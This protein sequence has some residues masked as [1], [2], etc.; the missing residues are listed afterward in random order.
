MRRSAPFL[1]ALGLIVAAA[2]ACAA[3]FVERPPRS[4]PAVVI[5]RPAPGEVVLEG[6]EVL[7]ESTSVDAAGVTEVE[8]Y[9]DGQLL[10]IDVS[11]E[12]GGQSP[13]T[14]AQPWVARGV[15]QHTV[16]VK[17]ANI[18]GGQAESAPL[19]LEVAVAAA[20][21]GGGAA[22]P[23][24][25][26]VPA[27][28]PTAVVVMITPSPTSSPTPRPTAT[29]APAAP[30]ATP[31]PAVT[32]ADFDDTGLRPE[33]RFLE[34]WTEL[35][36]GRGGLGYPLAA[37]TPD[38][39][40]ARQYF[41]GGFMYWWDSP[42]DPNPI[43]VFSVPD[44]TLASGASWTR[45]DDRWDGRDRYSC[46]AARE[47]PYGPVAGFG[48]VWCD[49]ARVRNALGSPL[50]PEAGSAGNAPFGQVQFFQGGAMLY[51]PLNGEVWVLFA[52]DG[53][54]RFPY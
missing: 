48:K 7:I 39:D 5:S 44:D 17:A 52:G 49:E 12:S 21:A 3:P 50:E 19:V 2:S 15:G 23:A 42:T 29:P 24:P 11:P 43:W 26:A 27:D 37:A 10:R 47:H 14:V 40:Y 45:Y 38:R 33:G 54:R 46:Q 9:V 32:A 25:S 16:V 6:D 41:E 8:L 4:A 51:N 53:W 20:G 13:Y 28:T 36:A 18:E 22:T 30:S 35:G 31:T 1:L 34:I